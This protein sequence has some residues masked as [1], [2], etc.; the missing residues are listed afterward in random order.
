MLELHARSFLG[1]ASQISKM[2]QMLNG[3][4]ASNERTDTLLPG[5]VTN[6]LGPLEAF[7]DI[8]SDVQSKLACIAANRMIERRRG[9]GE[10]TCR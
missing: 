9:G 6:V 3:I 2:R 4:D 7:R 1:V 5:T 10:R 8:A